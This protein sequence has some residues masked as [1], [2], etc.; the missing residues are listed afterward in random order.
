MQV[1]DALGGARQGVEHLERQV[2][3]VHL[4][5]QYQHAAHVQAQQVDLVLQGVRVDQRQ[6]LQL[7]FPEAV[8]VESTLAG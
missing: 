4:A 8:V 2:Q 1:H 5:C 6:H 3:V 7:E